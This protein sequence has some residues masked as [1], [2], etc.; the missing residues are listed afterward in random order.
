[1][2]ISHHFKKANAKR[3]VIRRV[4]TLLAVLCV[5]GIGGVM[6]QRLTSEKEPTS[7]VFVG[8]A[9]ASRVPRSLPLTTA[10]ARAQVVVIG[11]VRDYLPDP[12]PPKQNKVRINDFAASIADATMQLSGA[13]QIEVTQTLK[14]EGEAAIQLRLP[15]LV[16]SYYDSDQVRAI[17]GDRVLLLLNKSPQGEWTPV[18]DT[19]PLIRLANEAQT[20]AGE[21][22]NG[23]VQ[24]QVVDQMIASLRDPVLR[25]ANAYLLRDVVSPALAQAMKNYIND[26]DLRTRDN[27]LNCLAINQDVSAIP[28]IAQLDV[29]VAR[30]KKGTSRCVMAISDYETPRAVP[31]LNALLFGP[32]YFPRYH[33]AYALRDLA[34]RTSIPYLVLSLRSPDP[35]RSIPYNAYATLHRLIPELG[36]PKSLPYFET[37]SEPEI[38][39]IYQWWRDELNG[40]HPRKAQDTQTPSVLPPVAPAYL[41]LFD[42]SVAKRREAIAT[43]QKT[44]ERDNVLYLI[45]A[46]QDPDLEVSYGAY[47]ALS[48]FV[49]KLKVPAS[50]EVYA[51]SKTTATQPIY[52]WWEDEFKAQL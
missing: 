43:L 4:F 8:V 45:L 40:K 16:I 15:P 35:Q 44:A 12:A 26:P 11:Q 25:P 20:S 32:T 50:R 22:A 6:S 3:R 13:Y 23:D 33:A 28:L 14:G 18:D 7:S 34:D 39:P 19:V 42:T 38:E 10:I 1:M 46:L 52:D 48:R 17:K 24:S 29:E 5:L 37:R 21:T 51:R 27:A 9:H 36:P 31:Y 41:A 2:N 49:P 47:R 30:T